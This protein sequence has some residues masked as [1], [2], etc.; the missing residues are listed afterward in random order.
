[1][2]DNFKA[3]TFEQL[4]A[5]AEAIQQERQARRRWGKW[6]LDTKTLE[7]VYR[8]GRSARYYIDLERMDHS[9]AML[10]WIFQLL[11]KN[12]TSTE[13]IGHLVEALEDIFEPQARLCS[14]GAAGAPS[15]KLDATAYLRRVYPA[16]ASD[17]ET[18]RRGGAA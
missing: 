4:C 8:E 13:D 7:L 6:H 9:A 1:M 16:E 12:W 5:Q 11:K 10:D 3:Y 14:F 2:S 18:M 15:K 17:S